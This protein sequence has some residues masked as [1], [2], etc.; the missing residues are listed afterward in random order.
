MVTERF[1][2]LVEEAYSFDVIIHGCNCHNTMGAGIAKT[3]RERWPGAYDADTKAYEASMA[4]LGNISLYREEKLDIINCYTQQDTAGAHQ[5]ARNLN[6]EALYRCLEK[7]SKLYFGKKIGIPLIGCGL[8]GGSWP[9]V[10][11]M[12]YD[13]FSESDVT[14]VKFP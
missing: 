1:G 11:A 5:G 9:I 8:A 4:K 13:M 3:I 14:I 2:N 7:V 10:R 12:I 6:Y